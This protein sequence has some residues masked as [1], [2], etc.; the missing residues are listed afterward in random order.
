MVDKVGGYMIGNIIISLI[1]GV[2]SFI[3]FTVLG[4][5]FPARWRSWSRSA[6]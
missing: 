6:T 3:A 2:V 1:A 5:P 4:V